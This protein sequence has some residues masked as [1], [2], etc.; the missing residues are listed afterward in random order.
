M[1]NID[2]TH[3]KRPLPPT[4]LKIKTAPRKASEKALCYRKKRAIK[5]GIY[6]KPMYP[7]G[8]NEGASKH[9]SY[10]T[11]NPRNSVFHRNK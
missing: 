9:S 1:N 10:C 7:S 4:G 2:D 6:S 8:N 5:T 11:T 3:G